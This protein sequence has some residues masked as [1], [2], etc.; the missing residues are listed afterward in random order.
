ML[1]LIFPLWVSCT[2]RQ[3]EPTRSS[4]RAIDT[5]FQKQVLLLQPQ[6]DSV[7]MSRMDSI[8]TSAVDSMLT[9]RRAEMI[10]LVQ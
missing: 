4:R 7:C 10:Q 1:M 9:E 5:I 8:F 6:F 2:T 3:V